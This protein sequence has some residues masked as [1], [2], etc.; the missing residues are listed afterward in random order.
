MWNKLRLTSFFVAF[1]L[2]NPALGMNKKANAAPGFP[3]IIFDSR[4]GSG[5]NLYT[6][7]GVTY[8]ATGAFWAASAKA[9]SITFDG[10]NFTPLI[11]GTVDLRGAF[12]DSNVENQTVTG[13]FTTFGI[14]GLDLIVKDDSGLLLAG[15]YGKR[16]TKCDI[17]SSQFTSEATLTV[18]GGSLA[19]FFKHNGMGMMMNNLFDIIPTCSVNTF[20]NNFDGQVDGV[21]SSKPIPESSSVLSLLALGTLGAAS[22]LK[23]QIKPSKSSEKETTKV[24]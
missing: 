5:Q 12:I 21:I 14:P 1:V 20:E 9:V 15:T 22:T 4:Q 3:Q 19:S 13:N 6:T 7:Q 8:N 24:G 10:I 16:R 23:R 11:N 18:T 2:L 17:G